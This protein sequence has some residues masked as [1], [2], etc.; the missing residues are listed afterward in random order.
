MI[1]RNNLKWSVC[2]LCICT[3][4]SFFMIFIISLTLIENLN[5]QIRI[6]TPLTMQNMTTWAMLPGALNYKYTKS[7][8]LFSIDSLDPDSSDINMTSVGP[9][10]YTIERQ[11][12]KPVYDDAKKVVNYTM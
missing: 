10:N 4:V 1:I 9:F 11:F 3:F 12:V 8:Y 5:N 2:S 7:V 6:F